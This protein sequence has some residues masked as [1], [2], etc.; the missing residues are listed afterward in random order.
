[1]KT[2]FIT[3]ATQNTGLAIARYFAIKGYQ[4]AI[5]SR[6]IETAEE[7]AAELSKAYGIKAKGYTLSL[8]DV[9]EIKAVFQDVRQTFGGLDVFVGN[10][11]NLG[12]GQDILA[13]TEEEFD[14]VMDV[15]IKGNY[16]CCQQAALLMKSS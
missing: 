6:R 9:G 2:V 14:S 15:N 10:A 13:A 4:I 11:A 8:T 7:T 12:I 16:F 5:S 3:G 1:M